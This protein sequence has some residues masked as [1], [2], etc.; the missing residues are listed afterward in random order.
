[1]LHQ[2]KLKK[3]A[4]VLLA[5]FAIGACAA[6]QQSTHRWVS[7][8]KASSHYRADNRYCTHNVTGESSQ[9]VFDPSASQYKAYVTCM[10]NRGYELTAIDARKGSRERSTLKLN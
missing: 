8:D 1:M 10:E 2:I 5:T 6:P 3:T 9:R 4:G 7:Y